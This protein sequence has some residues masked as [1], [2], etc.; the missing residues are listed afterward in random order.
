MG[1]VALL[2]DSL[3]G[4]GVL[5]RWS[6]R[7]VGKLRQQEVIAKIIIVEGISQETRVWNIFHVEWNLFKD[8]AEVITVLRDKILGGMRNRRHRF[9]KKACH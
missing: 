8:C 1:L 2:A 3:V 7:K 9:P 6:G 4:A 5:V